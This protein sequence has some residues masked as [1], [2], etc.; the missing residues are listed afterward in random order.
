MIEGIQE[1][2]LIVS[3]PLDVP[4]ICIE[5]TLE[6]GHFPEDATLSAPVLP[7]PPPAQTNSFYF[8]I[9]AFAPGG[10]V[11]SQ[12]SD[13]I[14][15][16]MPQPLPV[17]YNLPTVGAPPGGW[18]IDTSKGDSENPGVTRLP[19]VPTAGDNDPTDFSQAVSTASIQ[20]ETLGT[21]PNAVAFRV[22]VASQGGV[23]SQNAAKATFPFTIW[24][25]QNTSTTPADTEPVVVSDFV[26]TSRDLCVCINS[27]PQN[28]CVM[29]G[30]PEQVPYWQSPGPAQ[31]AAASA[32]SSSSNQSAGQAVS[33]TTGLTVSPPPSGVVV[34]T[35]TAAS[36][37]AKQALRSKTASAARTP[38]P[39]P[40]PP[41]GRPALRATP[42]ASSQRSSIV[43][44]SKLKIPRRLLGREQVQRSR[45]PAARELM[46]QIQYHLLNSSRSPQRRKKG[47]VGF[48]E[49]DFLTE[50]MRR[51]MPKPYLQSPVAAMKG[52]PT[53]IA[54]KIEGR[55]TVGDVLGLSLHQLRVSAGLTLA[56]ATM[57]R[58]ILMG[59][60][61][62]S[63]SP[64]S[65]AAGHQLG[66]G[67]RAKHEH[68][69]KEAG[70][71]IDRPKSRKSSTKKRPRRKRRG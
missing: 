22:V 14:D 29:V 38:S 45:T 70:S 60:E 34:T 66:R 39:H 52:L 18:I 31:V 58:R 9:D 7:T 25:V 36:Q 59:F 53:Q 46:H 61:R 56:E 24:A 30:P 20:V 37:K 10:N 26:V 17:I 41:I 16:G 23:G 63:S 19:P 15:G 32:S 1:F 6:T 57:L 67:D 68:H 43:Y 12:Y 8:P 54:S 21:P 65:E 69:G 48:L 55:R 49:S 64:H 51:R 40:R 28:D 47:T 5:A 62:T 35:S 2:L 42:Q 50:R 44:E 11:A 3:R 13:T 4:G 27:C 33:G 71:H